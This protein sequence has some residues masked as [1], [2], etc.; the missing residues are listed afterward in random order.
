MV[1]TILLTL[2]FAAA[3]CDGGGASVDDA[4]A[5]DAA[6]LD[7]GRDGR[8]P[9][10][11]AA[12]DT[13]APDAANDAP[14]D[15]AVDAAADMTPPD[16][17]PPEPRP[18][19]APD[20]WTPNRG[21]G[22]PAV[23][24]TEDQLFQNCA[25][26]RV[27]P[28]DPSKHRNLVTMYDGYLL[29][30][31]SP[32]FGITG[33][34]TFFDISDPC[35][36][37]VVGHGTTDLMR[38]SHSIG[39][40]HIGGRWAV[41]SHQERLVEGGVLFWDISDVERPTVVGHLKVPGYLYPDAYARTVL[42]VFWQAPYVYVGGSDNGVYVIDATDP[43]A[44]ELVNQYVFDPILRTGQVQAVGNLLVVTAAEGAR[45]ALLDISDP[46][47]PQPIP[48]GDFLARDAEGEPR[49]AYFTNTANGYLYYARKEGGGGLI[50]Y[51]IRDPTNPVRSG[52]YRSDGNGGYVFVK[53][54]NA[55]VG[56]S[57]FGAIYDISD[58]RDI[59][60][61]ARVHLEGDLD[62]LTPIGN[63]A[64]VAVDD[65]AVDDMATAVAPW[66]TEVDVRPPR[67]TW[68]WPADGAA[69]LPL[70]SRFGLTF[71]EFVDARSAWAG[72]VRLYEA[73]GDPALTRVDGYVSAQENIVNF[74]P[75]GPLKPSTTYVLEVP[76]GGI[77]DFNGN[78][79]A[80]PFSI[81][82]TTVGE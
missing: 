41:V 26:L 14:G 3:G 60:E 65:E 27:G 70:T 44:P 2:L 31:W 61:V 29:M 37:E 28:D 10:D 59:R 48:G 74:W 66:N 25:F 5:P 32:E 46:A 63:V 24:F 40:S 49:E 64:M 1:R 52:G 76:A 16:L 36:P 8:P 11:A 30:P 80:E 58:H 71:D 56:E 79:V 20:A 54:D 72:S 51:D 68:A 50:I 13:A 55:F 57:R 33:G 21:P 23:A 17:G 47:N 19:P 18:Y 73:D 12:T 81:R 35:A 69:D 67:V 22:G 53:N 75:E 43:R 38:E 78:A 34:L 15:A 9:E 45:T 4:R 77:V 82:V 42:S 6:G 62:T 7:A 39:F